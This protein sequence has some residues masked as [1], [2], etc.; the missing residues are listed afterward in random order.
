[1]KKGNYVD[2]NSVTAKMLMRPL[3]EIDDDFARR[4]SLTRIGSSKGMDIQTVAENL[5]GMVEAGTVAPRWH[6]VKAFVPSIT[7]DEI[8]QN[9]SSRG[10][11][12]PLNKTKVEHTLAE[13]AL[14]FLPKNYIEEIIAAEYKKIPSED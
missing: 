11:I 9:S 12:E 13:A 1:M 7:V 8:I 3:A 2:A 5:R 4:L 10:N 14:R 6:V